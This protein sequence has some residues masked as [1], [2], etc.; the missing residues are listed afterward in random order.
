MV[1]T[2]RSCGRDSFSELLVAALLQGAI[3]GAAKWRAPGGTSPALGIVNASASH[4]TLATGCQ[5]WA[6]TDNTVHSSRPS[7]RCAKL[8]CTRP[9]QVQTP[10]VHEQLPEDM[11]AVPGTRLLGVKAGVAADGVPPVVGVPLP[12]RVAGDVRHGVVVRWVRLQAI[13]LNLPMGSRVLRRSWLPAQPP[14][15]PA[16][17]VP[18]DSARLK[19]FRLTCNA[20]HVGSWCRHQGLCRAGAAKSNSSRHS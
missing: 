11:L 17:S 18:T 12:L 16:G 1:G 8:R 9:A 15:C 19:R 3:D 14:L 2:T 20:L 6:A 13:R 4:H 10:P 7:C 5:L